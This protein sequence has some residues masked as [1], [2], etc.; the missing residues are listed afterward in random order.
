MPALHVLIVAR[1]QTLCKK[2]DFIMIQG[3]H[4]QD[5][6]LSQQQS[7]SQH[8]N[9]AYQGFEKMQRYMS[10]FFMGPIN[11]FNV[12]TYPYSVASTPA[13]S[14][15]VFMRRFRIFLGQCIGTHSHPCQQRGQGEA[16]SAT[17]G[18]S[19]PSGIY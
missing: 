2:I 4:P 12:Q 1:S 11:V 10:C 5:H 15:F 14:G 7:E 18:G 16:T 8:K 3:S 9:Q 19:S 13:V 6:A 17:D